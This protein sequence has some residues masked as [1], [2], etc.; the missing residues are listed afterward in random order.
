LGGIALC[1]DRRRV[2][3]WSGLTITAGCHLLNGF[4]ALAF[5]RA[6]HVQGDCI[7]DFSRIGRQQQFLRAVIAKILTPSEILH[8]PSLVKAVG[9][10]LTVDNLNL[11]DLI[12]LTADLRGVSTG[13]ADFRAVPGTTGTI[14]SNG[15]SV[16]F[17]SNDAR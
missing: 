4:Q 7:P 6:R 13:N 14:A 2:D 8:A 10:N 3:T 16:V 17:M 5:V 1:L 9:H 12:H 15:E 11:A